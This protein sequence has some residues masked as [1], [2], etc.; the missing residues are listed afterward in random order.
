M[1]DP[2]QCQRP[3]VVDFTY[4][5]VFEPGITLE[6]DLNGTQSI[7]ILASGQ[8]IRITGFPL[9]ATV[10]DVRMM[11]DGVVRATQSFRT[12]DILDMVYST[13]VVALMIADGSDLTKERQRTKK[14]YNAVLKSKNDELQ[15]MIDVNK[16]EMV[17]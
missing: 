6:Y 3:T 13:A 8:K 17:P 2:I 9:A 4:N 14:L 5:D 10:V 15:A 16:L 11:K 7:P 12:R 1:P